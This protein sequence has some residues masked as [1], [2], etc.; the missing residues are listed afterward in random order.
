MKGYPILWIDLRFKEYKVRCKKILIKFGLNK[1]SIKYLTNFELSNFDTIYRLCTADNQECISQFSNQSEEYS[2]KLIKF[3]KY[4]LYSTLL[5]LLWH[6][7]N[8]GKIQGIF[9]IS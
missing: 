1:I 3:L 7:W 4:D 5:I 6:T 8:S 2:Y 9:G